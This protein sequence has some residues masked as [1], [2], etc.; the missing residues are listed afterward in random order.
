MKLSLDGEN[1]GVASILQLDV[2]SAGL[3]TCGLISDASVF[4]LLMGIDCVLCKI[5]VDW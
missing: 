2:S 5:Q 1:L 3:I 4:I